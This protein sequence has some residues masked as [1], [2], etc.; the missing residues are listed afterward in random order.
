MSCRTMQYKE[1]LSPK[2]KLYCA[3]SPLRI[4]FG[5]VSAPLS[6]S[7]KNPRSVRRAAISWAYSFCENDIFQHQIIPYY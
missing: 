6:T 3:I 4:F 2:M 1:A 5:R 7:A